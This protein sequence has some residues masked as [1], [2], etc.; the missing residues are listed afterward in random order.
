MTWRRVSKRTL[1]VVLSCTFASLVCLGCRREPP[2]NLYDRSD[3]TVDRI[4]PSTVIIR[5][6]FVS[7]RFEGPELDN[8]GAEHLGD[9]LER[10]VEQVASYLHVGLQEG[11]PLEVRI[12]RRVITP[13]TNG[14]VMFFPL[15]FP[16]QDID[17]CAHESVHAVMDWSRPTPVVR[18]RLD[19]LRALWYVEGFAS[20]ATANVKLL[21]SRGRR[22]VRSIDRRVRQVLTNR[23]GRS[24]LGYIGTDEGSPRGLY[25]DQEVTATFYAEAESFVTYL[26]SLNSVDVQKSLYWAAEESSNEFRKKLLQL[27]SSSL[28]TWRERWLKALRLGE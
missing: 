9:R 3:S 25:R 11:R 2:F 18:V 16:Q 10:C 13:H 28:E 27:T 14:I 24:I 4:T 21:N 12:A 19:D 15:P 17:A 6:Q 1:A 26:A 20:S 8:Q 7:V 22:P 5:R 23:T